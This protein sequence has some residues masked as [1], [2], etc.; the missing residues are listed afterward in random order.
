[1]NDKIWTIGRILKWTEQYFKDKGIESPRLDAEVLLAHV[2]EKQRIYLYVHFD[3]PLQPAELAA[4]R[5]MI[6]QRVLHVPVA[7]IL[8]EKEFMGLTFKVTADTLVPRP[9]TEILVQAAVERLKAMKGEKS[10]TGVLADESAAEEPAEGQP[11]GGADAEQEV[12]EPLHIADIGTGSGAI[13]LSVLRYLAGTVADTVDISPEARAVAEENAA[14]LGLADRVTFHTGDLLQ[15]L[16]GMTFAAILS[17]PP[18]IPEADIAG[19]APEVRLKEPHTAL[20]GGRDGLDFYRRLAKEAPAM[21]VPGG[22][23]AFEVGI[24]QAEPV[25]ALAKANPLIARTEIL[26]DYAG[27][28]RV[29]VGWRKT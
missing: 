12:A 6:K 7:Q 17:N 23:M 28:D 22:F 29:V 3:E 21:L 24:H 18:Y 5:E 8:G 16:R 26:P 4:Y 19:L 9:D 11:V 2:L 10:A 27:I 14:S 1:M 13:C 15:P 25:A 20:S